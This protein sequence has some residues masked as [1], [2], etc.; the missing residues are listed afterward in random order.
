MFLLFC[1]QRSQIKSLSVELAD[2][3]ANV[4]K[5]DAVDMELMTSIEILFKSLPCINASFLAN[6]NASG[7]NSCSSRHSGVNIALAERAFD[8]LGKMSNDALKH[9]VSGSH[10]FLKCKKLIFLVRAQIWD[11][12]TTDLYAS[13]LPSPADVETLRVYLI[14]PLYHEFANS[15][16]YQKLHSPFGRALL[17]LSALPK[18]CVSQWWANASVE[19]FERLVEIFKGVVTYIMEFKYNFKQSS[20]LKQYIGYDVNLE[21]ALNV[22]LFIYKINHELRPTKIAYDVFQFPE[23]TDYADLE[24]DY[25]RWLFKANVSKIA[26]FLFCMWRVCNNNCR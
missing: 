1:S 14:L 25:L 19:Y 4:P 18:K 11:G 9:V 23:L 24:Q 10:I 5:D 8:L 2:H 7:N 20:Q 21:I 12:I 13:L 6:G 3:C 17:R 26:R 15:K 22:L 16:H